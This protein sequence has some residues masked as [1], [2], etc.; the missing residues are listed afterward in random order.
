VNRLRRLFHRHRWTTIDV[1][2][3]TTVIGWADVTVLLKHCPEC[4]QH[5]TDN[6]DG[7]WPAALFMP[8]TTSQGE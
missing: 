3:H 1:G 8:P 2:H 6:I 5:C 4:G 7:R